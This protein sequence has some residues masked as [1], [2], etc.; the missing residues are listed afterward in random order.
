MAN[1][2]QLGKETTYGTEATTLSLDWGHITAI[3]ITEE[4]NSE[5]LSSINGGHTGQIFE[6]GLYWANVSISI[7]ATK[8]SLPSI[9]EACLGSRTDATDYTIASSLDEL[10][11]SIKASHTNTNIVTILGWSVKDFEISVA[12]G[13][14]FAVTMNGIARKVTGSAGSITS[15][16]NT[17]KVF[18][19]LDCKVTVGGN[20]TVL[21][22]FSISG[23]WNVTDD[24][25][26]GIEAMA[27]ADRRLI[28][29]VVKHT[30]DI[31]GSYEAEVD[32][33]LEIGYTSERDDEAIV[34]T[35]SRGSAN[36]HV[37][38]MSNTRSSS[39]ELG[40]NTDNTKRVMSY[41]YEA[42]D[43]AVTGDL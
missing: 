20:A 34:F 37:F 40:L 12:R 5:K 9:L 2:Y 3:N 23:N 33:D 19:D 31:S 16:A 7:L 30:L 21:N 43:L 28:N 6:D 10:S 4:E 29:C 22:N 36:E 26:R 32:N 39:R 24:E 38:T 15:T 1:K 42:L 41:N 27:S 11:Y 14:K 8:A 18:T 17:D 13:E 25:G 35:V